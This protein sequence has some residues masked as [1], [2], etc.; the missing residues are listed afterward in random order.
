M[1]IH[2][3]AY[4]LAAAAA[5]SLARMGAAY[6]LSLIASL[7]LGILMATNRTAEKILYPLIDVLQ[8]IPILGFFPIAVL[9]IAESLPGNLGYE[10]ASIFLVAT[11]QVWNLIFGVYTSV[12]ILDP[13]IRELMKIYKPTPILKITKIYIPASIPSIANNSII[14]WASGWFF[15]TS[16]E[17]IILGSRGERLLG[18][19]SLIVELSSRGKM[20]EMTLALAVLVS[21]ILLSYIAVWNPIANIKGGPQS[22]RLP[23]WDALAIRIMDLASKIYRTLTD[24]ML[25]I[26]SWA[27][28]KARHIPLRPRSLS[29]AAASLAT[30]Y[31]VYTATAQGGVSVDPEVMSL[32]PQRAIEALTG[33]GHSLWRIAIVLLLGNLVGLYLA[34]ISIYRPRGVWIPII[35]SEILAS[36]PAAIWWGI[37]AAL[38]AGGVLPQIAVAFIVIFQGA[39]WYVFFNILLFGA[40]NIDQSLIELSKIYRVRGSLFTRKILAPAILPSALAGTV[41]AWGGA[42]N[43]IIVAEYMEIG[44]KIYG[45]YGIGYLISRSTYSGDV[46]SL[47]IYVL[48][49]SIFIVALNRTFWAYMFSVVEKRYRSIST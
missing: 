29:I 36:F 18:L 45:L 43:S 49:L 38:I 17:I 30:V 37:L 44:G 47:T 42:W 25:K 32:L 11:S 8:S 31:L 21:A 40:R 41:A 24:A 1:A 35:L 14:S 26:E 5:L 23:S 27:I 22:Y 12:K 6:I 16:A 28:R 9:L 48:I 15:L 7:A 34:Y 19:G 3:L 46:A 33:L 39:T 2:E 13:G 10:L 4:T 20:I